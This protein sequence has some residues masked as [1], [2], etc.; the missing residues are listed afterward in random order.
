MS[1]TNAVSQH[2]VDVIHPAPDPGSQ[3]SAALAITRA[4]HQ[5]GNHKLDT[6]VTELARH[7]QCAQVIITKHVIVDDTQTKIART[8]VYFKEGQ[9]VDNVEYELEGT[10]CQHVS[11]DS[12]CIY[13]NNIQALFPA[14]QML[15]DD[16]LESYVGIPLFN[17]AHEQI[18]H[19]AALDTKPFNNLQ[20]AEFLLSIFSTYISTDLQLREQLDDAE[21]NEEYRKKFFSDHPS[22]MACYRIN[23]PIPTDL[24]ADE[25]TRLIWQRAYLQDANTSFID[26]VIK[27]DGVD[28]RIN[29][30]LPLAQTYSWDEFSHSSFAKL[31]HHD[32]QLLDYHDYH[33]KVGLS[34][35]SSWHGVVKSDQLHQVFII[36]QDIT[37]QKKYLDEIEFRA[38]HDELTGLYN[39]RHFTD[40]LQQQLDQNEDHQPG[41]LLLI[42]LDRFKEINDT[43]GHDIGDKLLQLI[44]PR[45]QSTL[46]DHHTL[47]A[48]LGGDEFAIALFDSPDATQLTELTQAI[49]DAIKTPFSVD[50][51]DLRIGCSVGLSLFPEQ[52]KTINTLM[53][54]AD[55]AM[56][57]AKRKNQDYQIYEQ[58]YDPHSVKRLSLSSDILRAIDQNELKLFY[59][60]IL[61]LKGQQPKTLGFEALIRWQHPSYGL[62]PPD[63]FL[64]LVEQSE[65]LEPMTLW[66]VKTALQQLQDFRQQG[67]DYYISVNFDAQTLCDAEAYSKLEALFDSFDIPTEQLHIE[68]TESSLMTDPAKARDVLTTMASHGIKFSVDDFGTGYSSLSYLK[69]LPIHTLK[70]DRTFISKIEEDEQ[71]AIIV[72]S[73]IQLAHNLGLIVIAEGVE[74]ETSLTMLQGMDC[75]KAQGYHFCKPVPID[76]LMSWLADN[77]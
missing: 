4:L 56:Y 27:A 31:P 19:M 72:D 51:H 61:C 63:E 37:E 53:R 3:A 13:P 7:L 34:Y 5:S 17:Q 29:S 74:N 42:D 12:I 70:I 64:P 10:P 24:P 21:L 2:N 46:A 38:R 47:L 16:S 18:G 48:R 52:G 9:L 75:D 1:H 8:L 65:M 43:L 26:L 50:N 71:D 60:P 66:V 76:E 14:D 20:L 77:T 28:Q 40:L 67:L 22:P 15:Q 62:I 32:Y 59:Q 58:Q 45:L 35:S 41:A 11:A 57:Q 23:P 54:C 30:N 68:I 44:G 73:T 49:V 36:I 39:R 33:E 55:V 25:Q 6:L 69:R